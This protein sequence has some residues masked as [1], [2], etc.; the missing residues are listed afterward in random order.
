MS[1]LHYT[2]HFATPAF[3]GN[4]EQSGQWRTPPIKALLRQ[5]WRVAYA[6]DHAGTVN[7]GAMRAAEGALFGT[8]TDDHAGVGAG[9]SK[10]Q[11]RIRL[12]E[13]ASG[14]LKNWQD[15][16]RQRVSHPE[17]PKA[18]VGAQLYL[19]Y[20]PLISNNGQTALKTAKA[21]IQAGIDKALLHLAIPDGD[22]GQHLRHALWLIQHYGTLGG[23]SRNGWG[24]LMLTPANAQTP[25][26]DGPL[27]ARAC[28]PWRQA[29][30]TDWPRAIGSDANGPL[31]WHTG[32]LADW[33]AVM[34]RLAEIKIGLRTQFPFLNVLPPHPQPLDR[35]WLSYPVTH[36]RTTA[37]KRDARLPN[38]LR[39]KVREAGGGQLRGVI[40][41]LPCLPPQEFNPDWRAIESVWLKV[42]Q[43]LDQ[44]TVLQRS[45]A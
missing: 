31:I 7:V 19:G 24:S 44:S 39:F 21:A 38:S 3:L 9:S 4:A 36:H 35:H 22:E 11:I 13:W 5:W 14:S 12:N 41:H 40:V 29:L 10:S 27:Q 32:A 1:S 33:Q 25:T 30:A 2:L 26:L 28:M 16:D 6:A 8:V 23:R 18:P 20:G 15:L 37:W 43:Y 42:H 45:P 34:R 17:V